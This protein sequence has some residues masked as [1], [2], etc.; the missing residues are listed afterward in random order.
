MRVAYRT[1]RKEMT[2]SEKDELMKKAY[3]DSV[4]GLQ[5]GRNW[6]NA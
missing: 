4:T 2:G 3:T 1:E 5:A 6:T